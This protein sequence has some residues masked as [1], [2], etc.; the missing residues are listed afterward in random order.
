MITKAMA[1]GA[2]SYQEDRYI[3]YSCGA[4]DLIGVFDGHGSYGCSD[5]LYE[6][7]IGAFTT[8]PDGTP[9]EL[10]DLTS[11]SYASLMRRAFRQM[12]KETEDMRSGSTASVVWIPRNGEKAIFAVLG[13][14]PIMTETKSGFHMSPEHNARTNEKERN[15]A[16][17]RGARYSTNGYLMGGWGQDGLQMSRAF[18]DCNLT[19]VSHTPQIYRRNVEDFILVA[20]DGAF[21]PGHANLHEES[22]KIFKLIEEGAD[23]KAIVDRAL[24][25]PTED[26][27]TAILW[28]RDV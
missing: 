9:T 11:G 14:S 24:A 21:D 23:A 17:K 6:H 16:I 15:A 7:F 19:F 12:A 3:V 22:L 28:R 18:G 27:V 20:T 25:V 1:Q 10:N 8:D 13:D 5:Y 26:N 4:G 2:R